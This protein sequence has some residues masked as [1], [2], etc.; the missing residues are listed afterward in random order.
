MGYF[1]FSLRRLHLFA[2]VYTHFRRPGRP[3]VARNIANMKST[4]WNLHGSQGVD[5]FFKFMNEK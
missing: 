5:Y 4:P 1:S 2:I 3:A